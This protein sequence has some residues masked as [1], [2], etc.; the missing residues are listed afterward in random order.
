MKREQEIV[1]AAIAEQIKGLT[2]AD[3]QKFDNA[4][5]ELEQ[6][7]ESLENAIATVQ[8]LRDALSEKLEE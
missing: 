8:R 5:V 6:Q 3:L 2:A 1:Q 4:I 7:K